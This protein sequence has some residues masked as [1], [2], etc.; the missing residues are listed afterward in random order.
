MPVLAS[1]NRSGALLAPAFG[2]SDMTLLHSHHDR[3]RDL[4]GVSRT[5][6]TFPSKQT[7][8]RRLRRFARWASIRTIAALNT[9]HRA[10]VAAKMR[11][12]QRELMFHVDPRDD[13]LVRTAPRE[14]Q[15]SNKDTSKFPQRPMILGDK[16]D[17]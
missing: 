5:S 10:I 3:P 12:L 16:W 15:E 9:I 17:F 11:R 7:F 13:G 2:R 1:F 8:T 4:T 14:S 6:V